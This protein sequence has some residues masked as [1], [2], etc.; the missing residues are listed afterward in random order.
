V[1]DNSQQCFDH[2]FHSYAASFQVSISL[3]VLLHFSRGACFSAI[4]IP[5]SAKTLR[6][7]LL[8]ISG[9][10]LILLSWCLEFER[11]RRFLKSAKVLKLVEVEQKFL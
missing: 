11:I 4:K 1:S 9:E 2:S 6:G 5:L 10:N 3:I 8:S 7:K